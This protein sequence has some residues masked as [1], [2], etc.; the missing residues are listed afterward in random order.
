[1]GA[2]HDVKHVIFT[3][4][5]GIAQPDSLMRQV[6][7]VKSRPVLTKLARAEA[8]QRY[9]RFIHAAGSNTFTSTHPRSRRVL[10]HYLEHRPH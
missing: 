10:A 6:R 2:L 8:A 9:K 4:P 1:M 3:N 5:R 7:L